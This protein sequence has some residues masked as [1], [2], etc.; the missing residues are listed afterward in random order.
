MKR[1]ALF[2]A[3]LLAAV[4]AFNSCGKKENPY[5]PNTDAAMGSVAANLVTASQISFSP[6]L[7][8]AM[9]DFDG[10]AS[11]GI[12]GQVIIVFPVNMSAATV[13]LANVELTAYNPSGNEITGLTYVY[14]PEIRRMVIS[15][16][17]AN[18]KRYKITLKTGLRSQGGAAV[19]GNGN[20]RFDGSPYDDYIRHFLTGTPTDPVP[21]I[22]H[23]VLT[24]WGPGTGSYTSQAILLG[25]LFDA[26][27]FDT[28]SVKN[29][30]TLRD[31]A[32]N[33]VAIKSAGV[34]GSAMFFDGN[35]AADTLRY[36]TRYYVT[37]AVNSITDSQ[38]VYGKRKASWSDYGYVAS[39][40][41]LVWSFRRQAA[42][43]AGQDIT[44]LS[45]T[46]AFYDGPTALRV[47]CNDSLDYGTVNTTNAKV[48]RMSGG[49][50]AELVSTRVFYYPGD[51][52]ARQFRFTTVDMVVGN[53]YQVWLSRNL[54]D[55]AGWYLDGN[56]NGIGGEAGDARL[57]IPS[58]DV[59]FIFTY[60]P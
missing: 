51:I 50:I 59:K 14:Y 53:S 1:Y 56:G 34:A 4:L 29:T 52:S 44:P 8:V 57:G 17:F 15:G 26:G 23:P 6:G 30:V 16:T 39:V 46:G 21:D 40:P 10:D 54:R 41:N 55:N 19:D 58:D 24:A 47:T 42:V 25:L 2:L 48:F 37:V 49:Q 22:T 60:S 3:V 32:G 27:D 18:N 9:T 11:N 36:N 5:E 12:Q 13:N 31:S 45:V 33:P 38:S 35:T 7:G 20:G 28:M 43:V